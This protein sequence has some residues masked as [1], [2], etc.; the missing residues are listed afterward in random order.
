MPTLASTDW[1]A[2]QDKLFLRG[3]A[4]SS[5]AGSSP[6]LVDEYLSDQRLTYSA[7]DPGLRLYD[8]K[9]IEI[10][11][12][13]QGTLYGLGAIG[14]LIRIEPRPS[15]SRRFGG[16]VWTTVAVTQHG[17]FGGD[18][19]A[20]VNV[21]V[22]G[23]LA[24]R[25]VGYVADDA[26]YIN[27]IGRGLDD[28]NSSRT[29]GGRGAVRWRSPSGWSIDLTGFGQRIENRD[30]PYA[31][32]GAAPLTRSSAVAEPSFDQLAGGSAT[33]SG[34]IEKLHVTS[35]TGIVEQSYG[36]VF[37]V[38][39]PGREF[40]FE[41]TDRTRLLT[42]ET[43]ISRST[44]RG[45]WVAG[46][47]LLDSVTR[48]S[49]A[50]GQI[51]LPATLAELTNT[52]FDVTAFGEA[53]HR[54]VDG[55]SLTLGARYSIDL[56]SGRVVDVRR[57]FHLFQTVSR[58]ASVE[59]HF[60]PDASLSYRLGPTATLFVRY[61]RGFR[62][63][64]L[65]GDDVSHA[66]AGD[67]V[68]TIEA[69]G[70]TGAAGIGALIFSLTGAVTRWRNIQA[71]LL[72]GL[73]LPYIAN[74]GDGSIL[75]LDADASLRLARGWRID[76]AGFVTRNRLDPSPAVAAE[77]NADRLPNVAGNGATL[78]IAHDQA[79]GG[80]AK[81]HAEIALQHVGRSLFGIGP[82]LAFPQG[83]YTTVGLDGDIRRGSIDL[84]L[85]IDNLLDSRADAFAIG[86]PFAGFEKRQLTPLR[87]RTVR[88]GAR[89][90]F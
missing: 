61:G 38:P 84:T 25:L 32:R 58:L 34:D 29:R 62:T 2:G 74:I 48:Q 75:T 42:H 5:F 63:G 47:D 35:T 17:G 24:V 28:V 76:A 4:D 15:D 82:V 87:P 31:D 68:E 1:G 45:S 44:A 46:V 72:D 80:R 19:G 11:S 39:S 50:Y 8:V 78:T 71:D 81:L 57:Q 53:T 64:G 23:R 85:D 6:A 14:G 90:D 20:V 21:P 77:D 67:G 22:T 30:A 56:L 43:R 65:T 18:I 73:G 86:T 89:Y 55:L 40:L 51:D 13:P 70:R 36:Q 66:Y 9:A 59:H 12:G 88:L 33:V 10:L 7:P 52:V 41:A 27:D 37:D 83:G 60:L 3:I 79:I 54:L 49:N 26:G 16:A 69:G